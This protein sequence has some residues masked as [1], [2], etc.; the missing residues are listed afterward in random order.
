MLLPRFHL[1]E[2][3]AFFL[4]MP[5][6]FFALLRSRRLSPLLER[7]EA[8]RLTWP[9]TGHSTPIQPASHASLQA[10]ST[11]S[12]LTPF[13]ISLPL[14]SATRTTVASMDHVSQECSSRVLLQAALREISSTRAL[15][16]N[17]ASLD[18]APLLLFSAEIASSSFLIAFLAR[19]GVISAALRLSA[20]F[21]DQYLSPYI[22]IPCVGHFGVSHHVSKLFCHPIHALFSYL[23]SSGCVLLPSRDSFS[24]PERATRRV[25]SRSDTSRNREPSLQ[26][27]SQRDQ[28]LRSLANYLCRSISY[29]RKCAITQ[30]CQARRGPAAKSTD[31]F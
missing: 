31:Q 17:T 22:I 19:H 2:I 30:L 21:D 4:T 10:T 15:N 7:H 27:P 16:P 5:P 29:I 14:G 1:S 9:P 23:R 12:F 8:P 20:S 25:H 24:G 18:H 13:A 3:T 26:L 11:L 28:N 6:S